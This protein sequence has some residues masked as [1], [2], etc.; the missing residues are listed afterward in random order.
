MK[1]TKRK[2]FTGTK[3]LKFVKMF[4]QFL[5]EFDL[6]DDQA[7]PIDDEDK[8]W[9]IELKDGKTLVV[10]V[11]DGKGMADEPMEMVFLKVDGKIVHFKDVE[12]QIKD[13]EMAKNLRE[14]LDD[15]SAGNDASARSYIE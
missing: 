1:T 6:A 8:P 7:D 10:D 11:Q 9:E 4:E 14:Y 3:K 12:S 15:V 2:Y 13:P 5:N